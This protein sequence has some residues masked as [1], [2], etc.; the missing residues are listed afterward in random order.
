MENNKNGYSIEQLLR[1]KASTPFS[2]RLNDWIVNRTN[3]LKFTVECGEE[4]S[5]EE[6]K[7]ATK[8]HGYMPISG[9]HCDNTI[10]GDPYIN[11]LFRAWHDAK[12]LELNE[13]FEYMSEARVAFAQCAELPEDWHLERELILIEVIA[14]AASHQKTGEFVEN[15]RAFTINVLS[16]GRI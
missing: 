8:K 9:D 7:K 16:S 1:L 13:D 3:N 14:Q 2:Q 6:F 10:F 4:M 15:Q 11:I 12:H 5:F